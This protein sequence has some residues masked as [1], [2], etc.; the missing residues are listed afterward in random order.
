MKKKTALLF[1]LLLLLVP[2]A[3]LADSSGAAYRTGDGWSFTTDSFG[4]ALLSGAEHDSYGIVKIP[5]TLLGHR[6]SEIGS[7]TIRASRGA[8]VILPEGTERIGEY[9]FSGSYFSVYIPVSVR[10]I[11]AAAFLNCT[12]VTICTPAGSA[13]AAF[14]EANRLSL[15]TDSRQIRSRESVP[16]DADYSVYSEACHEYDRGHYRNAFCLLCSIADSSNPHAALLLGE[17]LTHGRG[18]ARNKYA[19]FDYYQIAAD[20]G[21]ARA[22][23]ETGRCLIQGSGISKNPEE[24]VRYFRM[25]ADQQEPVAWLW[26]GYC[27]HKGLGVSRNYD[28]AEDLYTR[29]AQANVHYAPTRLEELARDRAREG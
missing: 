22:Q 6:V 23:Y 5:D 13:A 9:A 18:A 15:V 19:A 2:A 14:A 20:A 25:A 17:C 1:A 10:E 16:S 7:G 12:G 8:H 27:Y 28:M 11:R 29:A 24:A 3:S 21:L 26:L 4:N